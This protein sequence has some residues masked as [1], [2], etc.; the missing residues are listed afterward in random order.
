[1]VFTTGNYS[2]VVKSIMIE[3]DF[4]NNQLIYY[5]NKDTV[6][7]FDLHEYILLATVYR[8]FK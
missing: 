2:L 3:G 7:D 1:M 4:C 6:N 8:N 5:I